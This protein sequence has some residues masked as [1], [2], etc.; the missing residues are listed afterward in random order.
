[1]LPG[2]NATEPTRPKW[3]VRGLPNGR[4]APTSQSQIVPALSPAA[5]T[6]PLELN[7]TELTVPALA[8]SGFPIGFR[9]PRPTTG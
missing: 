4:L 2:L 3:L 1:M 6:L 7:A 8:C 5:S 9:W